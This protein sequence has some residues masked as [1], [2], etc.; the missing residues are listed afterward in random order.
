MYIQNFSIRQVFKDTEEFKFRCLYRIFL[1]GRVSK[2]QR[3]LNSDVYTEFFYHAGFQI[4][5]GV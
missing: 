4:Y 2:I 1:S 5:R 3:N